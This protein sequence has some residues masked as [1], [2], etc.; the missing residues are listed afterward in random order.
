MVYELEGTLSTAS[1]THVANHSM[2]GDKQG[3]GQGS[4]GVTIF[5]AEGLPHVP[6]P[7]HTGPA[8]R[9]TPTHSENSPQIQAAA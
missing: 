2:E 9:A 7:G 6:P 3:L 8:L 5:Q 1:V 4:P